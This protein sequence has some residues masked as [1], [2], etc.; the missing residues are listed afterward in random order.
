VDGTQLYSTVQEAAA[1]E[2]FRLHNAR[3]H[4]LPPGSRFDL[5]TLSPL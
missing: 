2:Y 3:I 1:D 5:N 4:F